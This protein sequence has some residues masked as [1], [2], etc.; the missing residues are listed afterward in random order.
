MS[1]LNNPE[2]WKKIAAYDLDEA[3]AKAPFSVRLERGNG[4]SA[5]YTALVIG[6][7]KRFIYLLCV[8]GEL[9]SPSSDVDKA[10]HLH[11]TYTRDYWQRF[12]GE[13][14]GREIHHQPAS[15]LAET[16][17]QFRQ[18]YAR[19]LMLLTKEFGENPPGAVWPVTDFGT[20]TPPT[21]IN[22]SR[23]FA[24]PKTE[25]YFGIGVSLVLAGT[26]MFWGWGLLRA[27]EAA[28]FMVVGSAL[29]AGFLFLPVGRPNKR[30]DGT[31]NGGACGGG[32]GS[33]GDGGGCGGD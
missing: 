32:C 23:Y 18:A 30:H 6:E 19:T 24:V 16:E 26:G 15:G 33:G 2:L 1:G 11:L 17:W 27:G 13:T 3:G 9:L 4:W 5:N 8:S 28:A 21:V 12:C 7:Y 20:A 25:A 29:L 22:S 10:W 31:N 14:L